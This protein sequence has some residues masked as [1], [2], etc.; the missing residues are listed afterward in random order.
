EHPKGAETPLVM[1]LFGTLER[2]RMALGRDPAEIGQELL[3]AVQRLNPPSIDAFWQGR[4]VFRRLLHMRPATVSRGISQE[5]VETPDLTRF[6]ILQC[7]PGDA[8]RFITFGMVIT[9]HPGSGR[10]NLG[11]YR[12]QM[13]GKDETGMH[14]QS[15]KGGRGHYW[16]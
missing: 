13:F 7:W 15:M 11:L 9:H 3:Q 4:N 2:I 1:N 5:S 14:W 16:E 6:P 10:R 8:G 12:L